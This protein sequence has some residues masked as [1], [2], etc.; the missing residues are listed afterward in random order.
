MKPLKMY[1]I[2][3]NIC[4][5]QFNGD[6][7]EFERLQSLLSKFRKREADYLELFTAMIHLE[8]AANSQHIQKFN[9]KSVN[10]TL[11]SPDKPIFKVENVSLI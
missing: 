4:A 7:S 8:E 3:A 11:L 6:R 2:P 1:T 9:M 5:I 10:L